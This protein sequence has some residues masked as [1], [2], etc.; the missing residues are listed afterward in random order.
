MTEIYLGDPAAPAFHFFGDNLETLGGVNTV[1]LIGDSL[2][3]DSASARVRYTWLVKE[4]LQ[5]I[6]ADYLITSDGYAL[7]GLW[8]DSPADLPHGTPVWIYRD[9]K[10]ADRLYLEKATQVGRDQWAISAVSVVGMLDLERHRGG[11]YTGKLMIDVLGEFFGFSEYEF[12][13][14]ARL[15]HAVGSLAECFVAADVATTTVNGLLQVDWKRTNLHKLLFAYC[16]TM[17]RTPEG[18]LSFYHLAPPAAAPEIDDDRIY[19]GGSVTYDHPVTDVELVEYTYVWDET[20]EAERVY[21]NTSAP[22]TEGEALV[23]FSKPVNPATITVSGDEMFVRDAN[24]VSAYVTGHG[25]IYAVPYQVQERTLSKSV[26]GKVIRK[27]KRV[28]GVELVNPV[29]SSNLLTKLFEFY[30]QRREVSGSLKLQGE[31]S[32]ELYSFTNPHGKQET[33]YLSSLDWTDSAITKA[34][35]KWIA[36]F[37]PSGVSSNMQNFVLLTGSGVWEVPE[38]LRT[39]GSPVVRA[40]IIGG[41]QGGHGG[42]SGNTSGVRPDSPG[43]GGA[44]GEGGAG[45]NVLVVD[46]NVSSIERIPYSC[47]LGGLGGSGAKIDADGNVVTEPAPGAAGRPT[48]FGDY[49]SASGA[50]VT[51]GILNFFDGKFYA[52]P[53]RPGVAGAAG[54]KGAQS[55]SGATPAPDDITQYGEDGQPLTYGTDTYSGG[56]GSRSIF[57]INGSYTGWAF[58][59]GGGGAAL[60]AAGLDGGVGVVEWG[61]VVGGAGGEGATATV[62]GNDAQFYGC[63]GDGGNGGGGGGAPGDSGYNQGTLP[64]GP[65]GPGGLGS[66]GGRGA[67]GAILL[68]F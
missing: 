12:D 45:G 54:G 44:A 9:G 4:Y 63:G 60:G 33:A 62:P 24:E 56:K 17:S 20:A 36:N 23:T 7:Y 64:A 27:T 28:S 43:E 68:I 10:A 65:S 41:G 11:V 6:D 21:D 53:G 66:N 38:A 46:L 52:R 35:C 14:A 59:A 15:Y 31:K 29:N 18:A 37:R 34:E 50:V 51:G 30:T 57:A 22:H 55:R 61:I 39:S 3:V 5:P 16:V 32:G 49:S 47:G 19:M 13:K 48:V 58:G 1:D 25:E 67:W 2:S 42:Y 8:N 40:I 26:E